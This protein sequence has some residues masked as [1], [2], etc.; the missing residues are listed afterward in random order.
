MFPFLHCNTG[1]KHL[2]EC[3][4]VWKDLIQTY[5]IKGCVV[6]GL[7]YPPP[8]QKRTKKKKHRKPKHKDT[9]KDRF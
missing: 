7:E 3:D 6:D 4:D 5:E 9:D 8:Y 2:L 1:N